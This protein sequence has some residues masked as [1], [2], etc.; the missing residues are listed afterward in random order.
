MHGD[1]TRKDA[2]ASGP[3]FVPGVPNPVTEQVGQVVFVLMLALLILAAVNAILIAWSTSLDALRFTGLTRALGATPRQV[4]AGLSAAQLLPAAGAAL[5]GVPLGLLIYDVARTAGGASGA[6]STPYG[7][8]PAI[9]PGT[10]LA[11]ALL[12]ALPIRVVCRRPVA[13]VLRAD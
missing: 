11:V 7:E 12:T 6:A 4:T 2:Q 9:I 5:L 13:E 8:L 1:L 10:L 3:A